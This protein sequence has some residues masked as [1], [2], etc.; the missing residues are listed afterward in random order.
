VAWSSYNVSNSLPTN[1]ILD[2]GLRVV[3]AAAGYSEATIRARLD[4][5]TGATDS[6]LH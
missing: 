4:A 3:Y 2:T 1:V 6:C 5:L